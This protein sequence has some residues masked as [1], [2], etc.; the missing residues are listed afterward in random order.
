MV[1]RHGLVASPAWQ[2]GNKCCGLQPLRAF[3]AERGLLP[4]AG[5]DSCAH[6]GWK[7]H[8]CKMCIWTG[9]IQ[10]KSGSGARSIFSVCMTCGL[11][12]FGIC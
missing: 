2:D 12:E 1:A 10:L 9:R 6:I 5:P 7:K 8:A 11:C 3:C 4:V